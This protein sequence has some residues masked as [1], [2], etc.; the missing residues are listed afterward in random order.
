MKII[1]FILSILIVTITLKVIFNLTSNLTFNF[2][3]FLFDN[4]TFVILTI[5]LQVLGVILTSLR[6]HYVVKFMSK[7]KNLLF[8]FNIFLKLTAR[9][10]VINNFIPSIIAGDLSKLVS[11]NKIKKKDELVFIFLDRCIGLL[12]LG[13]LGL[14]STLILGLIETYH[15]ILIFFLEIIIIVILYKMRIGILKPLFNFIKKLYFIKLIII[16]LS[17]QL[18]FTFSLY[19]QVIGLK[20]HIEILNDFFIS[21]FLIFVGM[22]PFSIN[23]W[24]IREW[25]AYKI[26]ENPN[27]SN[28]LIIASVV[29]GVCIS[30]SNLLVYLYTVFI[31]SK[32]P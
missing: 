8:N 32:N 13:N 21:S 30:I 29:F 10:N 2:K 26:V 15:L 27:D 19:I 28:N 22:M 12:T 20:S 11:P 4:F 3:S 6:W 7:N 24:G 5:L 1:K 25:S 17:S 31:N 16:S 18:I 23:G 14:I 9:A